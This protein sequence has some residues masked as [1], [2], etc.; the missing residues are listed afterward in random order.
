MVANRLTAPSRPYTMPRRA[1]SWSA[2]AAL[3]GVS[4]NPIGFK[5]GLEVIARAHYQTYDEVPSSSP[6]ASTASASSRTA[7][8]VAFLKQLVILYG[9]KYRPRFVLPAPRL[10]RPASWRTVH[11]CRHRRTPPGHPNP[12][13]G[14][15]AA[16]P[17]PTV[18][19]QLR[20]NPFRERFVSRGRTLSDTFVSSTALD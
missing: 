7:R 20:L 6:I 1:F 10:N 5:I 9:D 11:P 8:S 16:H 2:G 15:G 18:A 17:L 14:V 13:S 4:L 3:E 19:H 12:P